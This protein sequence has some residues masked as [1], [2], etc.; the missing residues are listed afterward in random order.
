[1]GRGIKGI[2]SAF[3]LSRNTVR[4][5]VRANQESGLP[6]EKVLEMSDE[7]LYG[8]F[9]GGKSCVKKPFDAVLSWMLSF[10]NT[11]SG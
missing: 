1:M 7:Q 10:R 8:M 3:G 5:Y 6:I 9:V 4:K 11:P 2:S